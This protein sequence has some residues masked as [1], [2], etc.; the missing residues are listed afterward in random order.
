ML[1]AQPALR[2]GLR[3]EHHLMLHVLAERGDANT[4]DTMLACGRSSELC[5]AA[6]A[7]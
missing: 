6:G 2:R 1:Q 3:P 5:R 7:A 4:L